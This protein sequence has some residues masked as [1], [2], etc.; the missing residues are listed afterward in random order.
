MQNIQN[1]YSIR[2]N[3][4]KELSQKELRKRL[5]NDIEIAKNGCIVGIFKNAHIIIPVVVFLVII[6]LID[7]CTCLFFWKNPAILFN[8]CKILMGYL[9]T[10]LIGLYF[11]SVRKNFLK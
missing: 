8:Q 9:L 3:S 1:D 2:P 11:Y 4:N 10:F 5:E 6:I 7:G